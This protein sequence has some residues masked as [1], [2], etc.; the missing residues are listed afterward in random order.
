MLKVQLIKE[1]DGRYHVL[2]LNA[3]ISMSIDWKYFKLAYLIMNI[4][5]KEALKNDSW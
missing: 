4:Y 5:S 1:L 3:Y 2:C